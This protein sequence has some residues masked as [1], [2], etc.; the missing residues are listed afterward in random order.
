MKKLFIIFLFTCFMPSQGWSW[1]L[2]ED[3]NK[4][5]YWAALPIQMTVV[6]SNASRLQMIKSLVDEAVNTWEGAVIQ[7][8]WTPG[9]S[10]SSPGSNANIVRWSSNFAKETGLDASKILAVT[11]RYSKGPYIARAELIIN[12]NNAVNQFESNLRTV[13]VHEMGHTMGLD[14]STYPNAVMQANLISNYQGLTSDDQDGMNT[15]VEETIHRE[16]IHYI[17]PLA[18]S[19][20]SGS[21]SPLSCGTVDLSG[22]NGGGG[23]NMIISLG[24]GILIALVSFMPRFKPRRL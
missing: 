8:L 13:I 1:S 18:K 22:G 16:A 20:D 15:V 14:H 24:L 7:N 11:V 3:F 17:S 6:D 19:D 2:T 4:G 21:S 10:P 12:G 9:A 5:F 23:G